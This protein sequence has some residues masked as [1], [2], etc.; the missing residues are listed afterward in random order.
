MPSTSS[1]ELHAQDE[2]LQLW[3]PVSQEHDY[4][5]FNQILVIATMLH[6]LFAQT[7]RSEQP[8]RTKEQH[9]EW[10]CARLYQTLDHKPQEKQL[11]QDLSVFRCVF[12][13]GKRVQSSS[14]L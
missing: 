10:T 8:L 13:V 6:A 12:W 4:Y 2:L 14:R 7:R 11:S 9:T 5:D 3:V 1:W